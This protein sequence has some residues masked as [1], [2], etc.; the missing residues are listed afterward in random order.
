[1]FYSQL[2][3]PHEITNPKPQKRGHIIVIQPLNNKQRLLLWRFSQ[4]ET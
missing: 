2:I 3:I 4:T 1:M